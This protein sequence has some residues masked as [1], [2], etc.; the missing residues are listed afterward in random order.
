MSLGFL[1]IAFGMILMRAGLIEG[2]TRSAQSTTVSAS[3]ERGVWYTYVLKSR[4]QSGQKR[5]PFL[6]AYISTASKN[7]RKP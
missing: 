4:Y 7:S 3:E 2:G 5:W 1:L 6:T